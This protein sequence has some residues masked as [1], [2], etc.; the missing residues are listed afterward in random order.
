MRFTPARETGYPCPIGKR[1]P[2]SPMRSVIGGN[3]FSAVEPGSLSVCGQPGSDAPLVCQDHGQADR[4]DLEFIAIST[5]Q[6]SRS[7]VREEPLQ[8][9]RSHPPLGTLAAGPRGGQG[10]ARAD[11][12]RPDDVRHG[13]GLGPRPR[14]EVGDRAVPR[15]R[16][17][18]QGRQHLHELPRRGLRLLARRQGDP[19][20]PRRQVFR[21]PRHE[22]PRGSGRRVHL[23]GPQHQRRGDQVQRPDRRDRPEA[24]RSPRNRA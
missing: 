3:F 18:R 1:M 5:S 2:R 20:L 21:H 7:P 8:L 14:R 23:R 24:A 15:Q 9:S 6:Q 22:D 17:R 13:A 16:R 4:W 19:Q 11:G 12:V 10:P